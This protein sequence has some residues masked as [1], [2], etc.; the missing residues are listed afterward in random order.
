MSKKKKSTKK[1]T[2]ETPSVQIEDYCRVELLNGKAS[3]KIGF[4]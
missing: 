3:R 1:S 2:K 4:V